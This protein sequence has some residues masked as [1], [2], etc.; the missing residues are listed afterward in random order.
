M[1]TILITTDKIEK[2]NEVIETGLKLAQKLNASVELLTIFDRSF[3]ISEPLSGMTFDTQWEEQ[4]RLSE[5]IITSVKNDH[6]GLNIELVSTIGI[7]KEVIISEIEKIK[8]A[9]V[10]MGIQGRSALKQF[11]IGGTAEYVIKHSTV[12]VIVVPYNKEKH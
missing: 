1:S 5:T 12:P 10:V 2:N 11:V 3:L 7:P 9:F 8:P 4:F 6:P